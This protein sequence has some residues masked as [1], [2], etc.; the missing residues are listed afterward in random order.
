M[1]TL[2]GLPPAG[3]RQLLVD[4]LIADLATATRDAQVKSGLLARLRERLAELKRFSSAPVEALAVDIEAAIAGSDT[5][6]AESLLAAAATQISSELIFLAAQARRHAILQGLS[7]LGYEVREGSTFAKGEAVVMRHTNTPGF[8]LEVSGPSAGE[9][10]Q[11]RVVAFA[12]PGAAR[13]SSRDRDIELEWCGNFEKLQDALGKVGSDIAIE[14]SQA[15]GV[16]PLKVVSDEG[17][18]SISDEQTRGRMRDSS[19]R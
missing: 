15:V 16:V 2:E 13:D 6:R 10:L 18:T 14:R 4:S 3:Q 17:R 12:L 1:A 19:Q 7:G 9:R 5:S 11:M 8:G